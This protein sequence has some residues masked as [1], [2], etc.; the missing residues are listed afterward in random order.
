MRV[1]DIQNMVRRVLATG[2]DDWKNE[3]A[4]K[5]YF[6]PFA[7]ALLTEVEFA[8]FVQPD[9]IT[10]KPGQVDRVIEV[11]CSRFAEV[12]QGMALVAKHY[13]SI[14]VYGMVTKDDD[15]TDFMC[16]VDP[17]GYQASLIKRLPRCE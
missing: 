5:C 11:M 12:V 16:D 15:P 13:I 9:G 17:E 14:I 6:Y 8:E 2:Y 1:I 4:I 3:V 10:I 7:S